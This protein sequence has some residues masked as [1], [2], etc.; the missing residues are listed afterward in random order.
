M[1]Q[2]KRDLEEKVLSYAP[3]L[4]EAIERNPAARGKLEEIADREYKTYEPFIGGAA[5]VA[6]KTGKAFGYMGDIV[7]WGSAIAAATNPLL[8]P[9][10]LTG[11]LLKKGNLAAQL[12]DAARSINYIR[13]TGDTLG[14]VR[15]I[16]AKGA[17]YLPGATVVDRGLS[18]IAEK[19]MLKRT[20][21][22]VA[23]AL[24]VENYKWHETYANQAKEAGYTGVANRSK[25]VIS[26]RKNIEEGEPL[27]K[28]A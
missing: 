9:Y 18:S 20:A 11:L 25:N 3:R 21:Y 14:G 10:M 5:D 27:R 28:A 13:K 19:R 16:V 15:N 17:S 7:F 24:G 1:I 8:A 26:P 6:S 23:D 22:E 12:P 2:N 4:R